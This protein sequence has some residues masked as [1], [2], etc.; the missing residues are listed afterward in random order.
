M[1]IYV[2]V[3]IRYNPFVFLH[4]QDEN[5][6]KRL[7]ICTWKQ[8]IAFGN[9]EVDDCMHHG[10]GR[11]Y[12]LHFGEKRLLHTHTNTHTRTHTDTHTHIE[13]YRER[14]LH[15]NVSGVLFQGSYGHGKPG[16][17]MEF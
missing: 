2:Q 15:L 16:K 17:V 7:S 5:N 9:I 12:G 4:E 13:T 11:S 6:L 14:S 3:Y 8:I 10:A 1:Y